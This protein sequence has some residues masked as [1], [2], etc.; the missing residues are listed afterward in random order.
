MSAE[1]KSRGI[2]LEKLYEFLELQRSD[3]FEVFRIRYPCEYENPGE[4][5]KNISNCTREEQL[6]LLGWLKAASQK[7]RDEKGWG[8]ILYINL[9]TD[10]AIDEVAHREIEGATRQEMEWFEDGYR[11]V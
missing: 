2:P 10:H 3:F 5:F 4:M 6:K 9:T 7:I 1:K 8:A 11:S